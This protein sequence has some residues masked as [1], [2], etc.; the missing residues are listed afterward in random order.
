MDDYALSKLRAEQNL[1]RLARK[2]GL[3][4]TI[5]RPPLVHGPGVT[6]N[7]L[8]LLRLCDTP[9]PLPLGRATGRRSLI[10]VDNLAHLLL[11]C[12]TDPRARDQT[13][14]V[15][16]G[17]WT[18]ADLVRTLRS[19]L[20]RPAR[21]LPVPPGLLQLAASLAKRPQTARRLL[22]DLEVYAPGPENTLDWTPPLG[23]RDPDQTL[24]HTAAW[25]KK[26]HP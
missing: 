10:H 9:A 7:F 26:E 16:D 3:Q 6:A 25:Y 1:R 13:W 2:T 17:T 19:F 11:A 24:A 5:L 14:L 15:S 12:A 8:A 22:L 21:L 20:G 23:A 4:P 18:T